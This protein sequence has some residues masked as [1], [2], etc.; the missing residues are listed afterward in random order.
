MNESGILGI[1]QSHAFVAALSQRHQMILA[2]GVKP[3]T[4]GKGDFLAK[5]GETAK[6]FFLLQEGHIAVDMHR[7][8]K[9]GTATIHTT[10]PGEVIGWSW[11]VPAYRWQFDC[12]AL[13]Q[14]KG[15]AF[16]ANWLREKCEQD[17]E[18]GYHLLK[19]L[20]TVI[21]S[22]LVATREQLVDTVK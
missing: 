10:G 2:S 7:P 16:D 21:A 12:R 4:A 5:E 13:D 20:V 14:V 6:S 9:A 22:R 11:I 18:L 3:F 19:Q 17:H 1:F 8:G 15:L